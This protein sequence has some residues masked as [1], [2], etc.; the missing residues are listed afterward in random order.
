MGELMVESG[1]DDLS[2]PSAEH[3]NL[4][5]SDHPEPLPDAPWQT[6]AA[7][8]V[9]SDHPGKLVDLMTERLKTRETVENRVLL[10]KAY[11][12]VNRV[13]EAEE[14]WEAVLKRRPED[15]LANIGL[16]R[17]PN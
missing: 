3:R 14:Q 1:D 12:M 6:L 10:A 11:E 13:S 8:F 17:N 15:P 7:V 16:V 4:I 2:W 9:F 5:S